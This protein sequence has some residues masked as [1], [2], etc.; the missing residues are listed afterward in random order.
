MVPFWQKMADVQR[1]IKKIEKS[2]QS[3]GAVMTPAQTKLGKNIQLSL[4]QKLHDISTVFRK[5][6]SSYLQSKYF[7]RPPCNGNP[8]VD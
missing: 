8:N 2:T 4:A 7:S 1:K 6:Q 5:E 3:P